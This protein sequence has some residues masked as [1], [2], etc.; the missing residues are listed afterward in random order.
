MPRQKSKFPSY[1][2][3][4][5]PSH[6]QGGVAGMV[7][8][9]QPVE[10]EG[11][12]WIIPKEVVPDYLP[13]LQQITNEGR[14]MQQME[15]GNSAMD[16]LIASASM[17]NG[18]AQPKSP[19]Y[20]EGGQVQTKNL[21]GSRVISRNI[22]RDGDMFTGQVIM[23][24]PADQVGGDDGLRYYLS[25]P[26]SSQSMSLADSKAQFDARQKMAFA[27]ADSL[28][29]ALVEGYFDRQNKK[30]PLDFL[31]KLIGKKQGGPIDYY[32]TGGEA[33]PT[34]GER[35]VKRFPSQHQDPERAAGQQ[36]ALAGLIDFFTP[37]SA[38]EVGLTLAAGPIAG[39]VLKG[40]KTLPKLS[41]KA[42]EFL[43]KSRKG[44]RFEEFDRAESGMAGPIDWSGTSPKTIEGQTKLE[45]AKM[46]YARRKK[47]ASEMDMFQGK[48]AEDIAGGL[49]PYDNPTVEAFMD[50]AIYNSGMDLTEALAARKARFGYQTGGQ[51]QPR[52]QQEIRNPAMYYGPPIELMGPDSSV[53]NEAQ[54]EFEAFMD[55]LERKRNTNP[56]SGKPMDTDADVK[57]LLERMKKSKIPRSSQRMIMKQ[58]GPI[59]YQTGGQANFVNA[60]DMGLK[61]F[62]EVRDMPQ[63]SVSRPEFE[64]AMNYAATDDEAEAMQAESMANFM[65]MIE[66]EKRVRPLTPDKYVMRNGEMSDRVEMNIPKLTPAYLASYGFNTPI[67]QREGALLR[68]KAIAPETLNPKVKGL[69][70]RALVRR[71]ANEED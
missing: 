12:E 38:A 10:L 39:K 11:G 70:N 50:D 36:R 64:A 35:F 44:E 37:Q 6:E 48:Y 34:W 54:S 2:L 61:N 25:E 29:A 24:I 7:A 62:G 45:Q 41:K 65:A 19:M 47:L 42:K 46:E 58:G 59:P 68:R 27:Q 23:G 66:N 33:T 53:Y 8:D 14:A 16:A 71:L 22:G 31:K 17:H 9:E 3:V 5:G 28:P 69:I 51:V 1:G 20:Q 32:Q 21:R 55:S 49:N 15:N 18:L 63:Y 60:S 26:Q 13:V 43:K 57:R 52:K 40:A 67:S 4:R 56:F 30:A